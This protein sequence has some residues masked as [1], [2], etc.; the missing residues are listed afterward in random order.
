MIGIWLKW[1]SAAGR[2]GTLARENITKEVVQSV[3]SLL[4]PFSVRSTLG[5]EM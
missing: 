4:L 2:G 3:S 1:E 5:I